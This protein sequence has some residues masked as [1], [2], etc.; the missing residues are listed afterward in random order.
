MEAQ[1]KDDYASK[2][3]EASNLNSMA[4]SSSREHNL[5]SSRRF[6]HAWVMQKPEKKG[7]NVP[8]VHGFKVPL[9]KR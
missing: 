1:A 4:V 3:A 7:M 8:P 5:S 6:S 9:Q 2:V